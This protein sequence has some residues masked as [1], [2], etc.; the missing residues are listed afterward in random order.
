MILRGTNFWHVVLISLA[1]NRYAL[2]T[3]TQYPK[4]KAANP[5]AEHAA[6]SRLIGGMWKDLP[7]DEKA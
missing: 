2:F 3:A 7:D 4:V 6:I 5:H 1:R